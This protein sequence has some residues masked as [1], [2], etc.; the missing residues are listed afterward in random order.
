HT[1][2]SR[3]VASVVHSGSSADVEMVIVAGEIIVEDG[4]ST[5]VDED[6]VRAMA[7]EAAA[8]LFGRAQLTDLARDWR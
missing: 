3:P 2:W 6:E 4:R 7:A 1:P 8:Q 5:R